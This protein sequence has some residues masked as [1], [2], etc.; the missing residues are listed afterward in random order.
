MT[1]RIKDSNQHSADIGQNQPDPAA[2]TR[3]RRAR[4]R[5]IQILAIGGGIASSKLIPPAWTTPVVEATLLPAHAASSGCR[6]GNS[7]PFA[8]GIAEA[9]EPGSGQIADS[10]PGSFQE[11]LTNSFIPQAIAVDGF[12]IEL[13]GCYWID[14]ACGSNSGTLY[15]TAREISLDTDEEPINNFIAQAPFTHDKDGMIGPFCF[16]VHLNGDSSAPLR[17]G[18]ECGNL[19]PPIALEKV[20]NC[21]P[22]SNDAGP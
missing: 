4:R 19:S 15:A 12:E 5:L 11:W 6:L 16:I 13:T 9:L 20:F 2:E 10:G 3:Q 21:V 18:P 14:F 1:G 7:E 22:L 8:I 17:V